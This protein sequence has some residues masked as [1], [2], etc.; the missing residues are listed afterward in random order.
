MQ[1]INTPSEVFDVTSSDGTRIRAGKYGSGPHKW[2]L[3]PGLGTPVY[4]WKYLFEYFGSRITFVTW[5]PRGCY[6][7]EAPS[8]LARLRVED[9]VLD[10]LAVMEAVGWQDSSFVC[11]GWSMGIEIAL[12]LYRHMPDKIQALMLLN[13]AYEHVLTTAF[14]IP[15]VNRLLEPS[16]K[17]MASAASVFAPLSRYL[18]GQPWA[19]GLMKHMGIVTANRD[20]FGEVVSLFKELDFGVYFRMILALNSHSAKNI[21]PLVQVPTLVTA[22]SMDKMTPL[23]VSEY[24]HQRIQDSELFVVPNG[25]HYTTIEYPEL[26]NLK[27]EQFFRNRVF[28]RDF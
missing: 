8:D 16:V 14:D 20:F 25:T 7:S 19:I 5:E 21:L 23:S 3:T 2:L 17:G 11:G 4:S 28:G 27:V 9:H 26:I 24:I 13:G 15:V 1:I 22:G 12:E 6:A 18:L 10:G